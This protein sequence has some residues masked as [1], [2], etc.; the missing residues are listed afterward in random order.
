MRIT[1]EFVLFWGDGDV[2][3]N[4]H[5]APFIL[6]DRDYGPIQGPIVVPSS[7]HAFMFFKAMYFNDHSTALEILKAPHPYDA[8]KLGRTVHGFNEAEWNAVSFDFMYVVNFGKY[9]QN[10]K[11]MDILLLTEGK[12]LVEAS[13]YDKVW[14]VGLGE[15]DLAVEDRANWKGENRLGNVLNKLRADLLEEGFAVS[16]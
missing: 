10:E 9:T 12:C 13:P 11:L 5:P 1:E 2:F 15:N 4:F 7:E 6:S 16:E 14:G 3:S 8:K